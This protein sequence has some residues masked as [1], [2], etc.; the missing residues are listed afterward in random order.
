MPHSVAELN[1]MPLG[2]FR[3]LFASLPVPAADELRCTYRAAFFGPGW[4]RASA[5]P[6]LVITGLGGWWGK[7]FHV[8]GTAVN[9]VLRAGK[10]TARFGMRLTPARSF[11]DGK[12]GL[13][14][15]YQD[16]NPFPWPYVVDELRRLDAGALLGMTIADAGFLRRLAFPFILQQTDQTVL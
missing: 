15:R 7:Q 16:G 9:I 8:D 13:S 10:Y 5:G 6:A 2:Y 3:E 14:L 11:V 4:L 12:D 1:R